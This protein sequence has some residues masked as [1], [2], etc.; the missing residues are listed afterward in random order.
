MHTKTLT[1]WMGI[2]TFALLGAGANAAEMHGSMHGHGHHAPVAVQVAQ[3]D[4]QHPAPAGAAAEAEP[5]QDIFTEYPAGE[6]LVGRL[7][8]LKGHL[9][10]G[11]ELYRAGRL[12]D[13]A[14]HYLHPTEEIWGLIEGEIKKRKLPNFQADLKALAGLVKAKKPAAE[15]FA[16]QD[17]VLAKLEKAMKA[18]DQK[19]P[20]FAMTVAPG[21]LSQ[22]AEEYKEAFVDDKLANAVEYQDARGFVTAARAY[23]SAH[24]KGLAAKNGEAFKAVTGNMDE[25]AKA[26]PT[27]VP[28][29]PAVLD[30][31]A[32]R[33][34]VTKVEEKKADFQ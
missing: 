32:V 15:V 27:A 26:F 29:S 12:D 1:L 3:A 34:L 11:Q 5:E 2:G 30:P 13:A 8:M 24:A 6:A 18:S 7:L 28:P 17:A 22:A 19:A 9:L 33:A 25:I 4:H 16:K 10:V 31:N 20:A 23:V 14:P 21:V